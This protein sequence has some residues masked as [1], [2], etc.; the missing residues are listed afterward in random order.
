M[1]TDAADLQLNWRAKGRGLKYLRAVYI[2]LK[3][4]WEINLIGAQ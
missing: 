4:T 3:E 1:D 2:L